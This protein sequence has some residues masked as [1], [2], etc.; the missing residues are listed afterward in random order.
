MPD[1]DYEV[2]V[3]SVTDYE[4][5][6]PAHDHFEEGVKAVVEELKEKHLGMADSAKN[7][8]ISA[9]LREDEFIALLKK[10]RK[11]MFSRELEI[12]ERDS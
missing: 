6:P 12:Y 7:T 10:Q 5:L 2:D 11:R 1:D 8:F 3:T 9:S 4:N